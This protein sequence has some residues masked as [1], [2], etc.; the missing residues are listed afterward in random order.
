MSRKNAVPKFLRSGAFLT[1]SPFS[2][3]RDLV[4]EHGFVFLFQRRFGFPFD[5]LFGF[6]APVNSVESAPTKP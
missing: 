4:P 6:C 1:S 5:L 2:H 3:L